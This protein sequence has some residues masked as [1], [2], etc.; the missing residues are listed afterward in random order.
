MIRTGAFMRTTVIGAGVVPAILLA[1][2]AAPAWAAAPTAGALDPAFGGDGTVVTDITGDGKYDTVND[3][4]VAPDGRVVAAG[5]S[6]IRGLDGEEED[7]PDHD[8]AVARYNADGSLDATFGTGG[9]VLTGFGGDESR[10]EATAVAV[11]A[12]GKIVV[13]GNSDPDLEDLGGLA[14]V[15]YNADGSLDATFGTGGRVLFDM[16]GIDSIEEMAIQANGRI[17]VVGSSDARAGIGSSDFDF[18]VA[19]FRTN[20]APDTSFGDGGKVLTPLATARSLDVAKAVAIQPN[21]RIVVVGSSN[22]GGSTDFA[23]ARYNRNGS[24][25]RTFGA[26]G[27]VL[28]DASGERGTDVAFDVAVQADGKI[29]VAGSGDGFTVVRYHRNGTLDPAFGTGGRTNVELYGSAGAVAV[30]ADGR[31]VVAGESSLTLGA[32]T[33][34]FTLVRFDRNGSPDTSFGDGGKVTTDFAGNGTSDEQLTGLAIAPDGGIVA[35]GASTSRTGRG[36]DF[37]VARYLP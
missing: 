35:A 33:R 30:Q 19:R 12:N 6:V 28:T 1:V 29:V 2:M 14:L 21:G 20:G 11:Q 18:A 25:D 13:A 23:V 7:Q 16:G 22:A 32:W 37:A 4:A 10:D 27:I 36:F 9:V 5:Y 26:G 3:V 17:V 15:R 34:D 31:I 8:F 24:L